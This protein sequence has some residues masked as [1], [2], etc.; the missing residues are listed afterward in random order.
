MGVEGIEI[1]I[2][3]ASMWNS[4]IIFG[5]QNPVIIAVQLFLGG[6]WVIFLL[7]LIYV[8]YTVWLG[9]RQGKYAN[10]WK[11]IFLA[12]DIPRENEQTPKA[13]ENIFIALAATQSSG[14]LIERFWEGKIQES[15]SF[16]IVSLEGYVQFIVRTPA[17]FRDLIE[18]SI[19]AQYPAAEIT[20]VEDYAA[21]YKD[22]K[23]PHADY[24]L[25]G[26]EFVLVNDYPYPIK[27]YQEFEHRLS[28]ELIDPMASL[29]EVM[30][31]MGKGE[32]VWM[33][34][35]VTPQK[36][37]WGEKGKKVLKEMKGE[38]YIPPETF[39]DRM[40]KPINF[41][42]DMAAAVTSEIF[43]GEGATVDKKEDDQWKMFKITPG[44]RLVFEN[45]N[46]KL[47]KHAFRVKF[48]M[49]YFGEKEGFHKGRGVAAVIGAV[50][51]FNIVDSNGFKPGPRT[52][53]G[54][55]YFR[56]K[57]RIAT[58][59]NRIMRSYINR[60]NVDGDDVDNMLLCSEELASLWHFPVMS[61]KA[62][63]VEIISAKRAVPPSRLPYGESIIPIQNQ[64]PAVSKST[65]A[66]EER[67][68][69]FPPT[70][71]PTA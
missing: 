34:F 45:I 13:V 9:H 40:F 70:N 31:R 44:E 26:T 6:G 20:E 66:E 7:L 19:Y 2:D 52:K 10:K 39:S 3:L 53:T 46:R 56:V 4:V 27:T 59:Q 25:W 16:E 61:V 33:Q 68:K 64:V 24:N 5:T 51:Q 1:N 38:S 32:H 48:R 69:P 8:L 41:I 54:A 21:P 71:L 55:D 42:G 47:S 65:A 14:N 22:V 29:L 35:V 15:F 23:F 12:I 57:K 28:G 30:G 18:A 49:I 58:R 60:N 67:S 62:P 36:P 11:H 37:G 63:G 17:H 50:Q 43:G